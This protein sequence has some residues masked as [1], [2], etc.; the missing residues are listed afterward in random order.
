[1]LMYAGV[2]KTHNNNDI[3][4]SRSILVE[5][6]TNKKQMYSQATN[7]WP[8]MHLCSSLL[9]P[10]VRCSSLPPCAWCPPNR[11]QRSSPAS[12][13]N[14]HTRM[15]TV[16]VVRSALLFL[17]PRLTCVTSLLLSSLSLSPRCKVKDTCVYSDQRITRV[18]R[19]LTPAAFCCVVDVVV[20]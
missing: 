4:M 2:I 14:G 8:R 13:A 10:H 12:V 15:T 6:G 20:Y 7:L 9:L 19:L 5:C 1:M 17:L 16:V 11:L 18:R 3:V